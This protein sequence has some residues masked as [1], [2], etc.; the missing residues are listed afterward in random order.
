MGMS[1]EQAAPPES[2]IDAGKRETLRKLGQAAWAIPVV[3]SFALSGLNMSSAW[4]QSGNA[5]HHS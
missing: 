3:A 2:E 1:D 5:R 4:A